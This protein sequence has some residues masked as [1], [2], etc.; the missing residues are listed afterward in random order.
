MK[1]V[2]TN[3][4]NHAMLSLNVRTARYC[5]CPLRLPEVIHLS[6]LRCYFVSFDG[7]FIDE[8]DI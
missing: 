3:I 8:Q 2:L 1:K 5:D 7:F 6:L 4:I